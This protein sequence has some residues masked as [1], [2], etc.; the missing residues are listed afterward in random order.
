MTKPSLVSNPD[1]LTLNW[2]IN[3]I[4]HSKLVCLSFS[5]SALI[6]LQRFY[7]LYL[8]VPSLSETFVGASMFLFS[9][10]SVYFLITKLFFCYV[11]QKEAII[12]LSLFVKIHI[13]ILKK[14]LMYISKAL[15]LTVLARRFFGV[16]YFKKFNLAI[17][18]KYFSFASSYRILHYRYIS[19]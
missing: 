16:R 14:A 4:G 2:L 6:I 18:L 3:Y 13:W 8:F 9:W 15:L 12:I 11:L 19:Q 5:V 10:Q 1:S 17:F 7:C